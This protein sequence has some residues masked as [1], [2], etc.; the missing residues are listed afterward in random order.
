[1]GVNG[2]PVEVFIGVL[3]YWSD[4]FIDLAS[5]GLSLQAQ[6]SRRF[7]WFTVKISW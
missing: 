1:M 7:G 2:N 6:P 5:Q 3:A 4:L